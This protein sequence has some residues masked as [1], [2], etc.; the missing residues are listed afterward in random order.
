[1]KNNTK[2]LTTVAILAAISIALAYV[3]RF[4]IFPAVSYLEYEPADMPV[5][6]GGFLFGPFWGLLLTLLVSGLQA[7]TVSAG[8]GVI[9]FFMH[10][11]ATSAYMLA[12]SLIYRKMKSNG[13][14]IA[15]LAAGTLAATL[16][17]IPLNLIFTPM[18][19]ISIDVVKAMLWPVIIPFNLIK[20]GINSILSY[21]VYIGFIKKLKL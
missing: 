9:G 5:I 12:A 17:M 16:L 15:G 4:P 3:V 10:V 7:M 11:I 19:G 20:F 8:S 18:Y 13:G 21:I 1:M 2:T 14:V 6:I